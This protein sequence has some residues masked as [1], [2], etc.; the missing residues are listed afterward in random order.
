MHHL[1]FIPAVPFILGASDYGLAA[2]FDLEGKLVWRD[3][4]VAH[5]GS[6]TVSGA[7]ER[8]I[9][10]CFTEGLQQYDLKGKN[11]GRKSLPEACRL[12]ARQVIRL[13]RLPRLIGGNTISIG[14]ED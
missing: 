14:R 3:A 9:L 6:L 2:C 8:V 1:A 5:I 13:G 12:A 4:L 11:L 10:A 7:G